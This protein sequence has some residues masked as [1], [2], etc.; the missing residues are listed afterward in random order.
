MKFFVDSLDNLLVL[1]AAVVGLY[2]HLRMLIYYRHK[3]ARQR[4][5]IKMLAAGGLLV[6]AINEILFLVSGHPEEVAHSFFPVSVALLTASLMALGMV[7]WG[8]HNAD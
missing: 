4:I 5:L 8:E 7:D 1:A 6:V 3:H 2:F